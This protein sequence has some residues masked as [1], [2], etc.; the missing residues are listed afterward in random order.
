MKRILISGLVLTIT[1]LSVIDTADAFFRRRR[2]RC[3][4]T[5]QSGCESAYYPADPNAVGYQGPPPGA[6]QNAFYRGEPT[7]AR[8]AAPGSANVQGSV[9][10]STSGRQTFST[11]GPVQTQGRVESQGRIEATT[12]NNQ[13]APAV[14]QRSDTNIELNQSTPPKTP[15]QPA[16]NQ[17]NLDDQ[18]L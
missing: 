4:N 9:Q 8:P 11:Q 3:C 10:G 1:L 16:P 13:N 5:V 14:R 15:P 6:D 17:T 12:P 18:D 2:S 7:T